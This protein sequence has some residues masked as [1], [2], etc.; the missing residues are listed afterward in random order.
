MLDCRPIK[1]MYPGDERMRQ[2]THKCKRQRTISKQGGRGRPKKANKVEDKDEDN[3]VDFTRNKTGVRNRL[4]GDI[5]KLVKD[6]DSLQRGLKHGKFCAACG[7]TA[8]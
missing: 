2:S 8:Y 6:M 5:G 4:C 3:F 7:K 1:K